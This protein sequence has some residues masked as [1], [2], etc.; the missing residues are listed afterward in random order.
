MKLTNKV[1]WL[2]WLLIN[3]LFVIALVTARLTYHGHIHVSGELAIAAVLTIYGLAS[4]YCGK[5]AWNE[6]DHGISHVSLAIDL[7]PMVAM[8]GTVSGFLLAFNNAAGDIQHRVVGA[9]TGLAS[10]FIGIACMVV[11]MLQRHLLRTE[12]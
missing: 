3:A 12:V 4:G 9:S 10:T 7:C 5:L 6:K 11:L 2:K 8:L 1:L